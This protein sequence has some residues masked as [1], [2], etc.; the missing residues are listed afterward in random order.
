MKTE[1]NGEGVEAAGVRIRL[2][3]RKL[4]D[5]CVVEYTWSDHGESPE[6][7]IARYHEIKNESRATNIRALIS[8]DTWM[9]WVEELLVITV[10]TEDEA[11]ALWQAKIDAHKYGPIDAILA[12]EP[13]EFQPGVWYDWSGGECPVDEDAKVEVELRVLGIL[14]ACL[15]RWWTWS[16]A[17]CVGDIVRF[18]IVPEDDDDMGPAPTDEELR[19]SGYLPIEEVSKEAAKKWERLNSTPDAVVAALRA[20]DTI[21]AANVLAAAVR[22]LCHNIQARRDGTW[23][24]LNTWE[25]MEQVECIVDAVEA[26]ET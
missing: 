18:R 1:W 13:P 26:M 7:L 16:H 21:P 19:A 2:T 6:V 12:D 8:E 4:R 22:G 15:G 24:A 14:G 5:K 10:N 17:D 11:R 25:E 20:H 23:D 3:A 9:G